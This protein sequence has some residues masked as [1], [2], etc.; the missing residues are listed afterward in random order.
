MPAR[1]DC[2]LFDRTL[3]LWVLTHM[4]FSGSCLTRSVLT[5]RLGGFR[6]MRF[7]RYLLI[8]SYQIYQHVMI[9]FQNVLRKSLIIL[10]T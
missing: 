7:Y 9:I 1:T 6:T 10:G 3:R 5:G 2:F 4:H 8:F